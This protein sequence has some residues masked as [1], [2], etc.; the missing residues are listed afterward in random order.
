MSQDW[1]QIFGSKNCQ[2]IHFKLP[3]AMPICLEIKE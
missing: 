2:F 3:P 1:T